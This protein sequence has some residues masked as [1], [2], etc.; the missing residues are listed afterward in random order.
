[1]NHPPFAPPA[2]GPGSRVGVAALSG[3]VDG[4]LLECGISALA[5]LGFEVVRATN[6]KR[7]QGLFAGTDDERLDGLH[8]LL[9]DSSL[10]AVF[11]ARGGHGVLRLLPAI[12][13]DRL[14]RRPRWFIGYSDLTPL[15][16]QVVTR[17]GWLTLHGPMVAGELARGLDA[18]EALSLRSAL[19]GEW[20]LEIP[21]AGTSGAWRGVEGRLLGGCLSLLAATTGTPWAVPMAD[22]V[23]FLEDVGE[24]LY[25]VDRMLQQLRLAGALVRVR[26]VVLG[27]FDG[28]S[29]GEGSVA[30]IVAAVGQAVGSE[31]PIAWGCPSGHRRPNVTLALGAQA[32][33]E[34]TRLKLGIEPS[35]R[36]V[37]V[38]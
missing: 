10:D 37:S 35:S 21:L 20:P 18:E 13:W 19:A 33:V 24:P 12:D 26:G 14:A 4:A 2:T 5:D 25:R 7:R 32:R 15:L 1:M 28:A 29:Q 3:A 11:F 9:D 27:A 22:S 31:V 38:P 6:L 34:G 16:M 36:L 23:L 17:L 30:E 8:G